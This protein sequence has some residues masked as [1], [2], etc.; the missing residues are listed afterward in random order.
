MPNLC[1]CL[2]PT[3]LEQFLLGCTNEDRS[4]EIEVH[5]QSCLECQQKLATL[6]GEDDLVRALRDRSHGSCAETP[7]TA[8]GDVPSELVDR[9]IPRFKRIA[10]AFEETI[11]APPQTAVAA[12][13]PGTPQG[14]DGRRQLGRYEIRG[15]LGRGG[16]GTVLH[17][18]DPLLNR[19]IAIKVLQTD[20]LAEEGATERLVREA[21]AAAAMEHDNIV[22]I[23]A[24][25]LLD[26]SPCIV[27]PLLKGESLQQRLERLQ[28]PI[29]VGEF[30][31]IAREAALGLAAAH[32]AGL[33]HCDIKP[34]NLWLESPQDRVIVLDFGLAIA[35]GD[36]D[37]H[38]GR[39]SG[40]PG[41]LAPEQA[42]GKPLDQRTDIFSLG[43][44]LYRMATGLA[45]FTGERRLR[46]LWTVLS[47]PPVA[48]CQ[49]NSDLPEELSDLIAGM[50][51]SEPADRPTT[52]N[53]VV[54]VLD[55]FLLR[56]AEQQRRTVRRRWML[57]M[58]GAALLSGVGVGTWA[59][60]N[61]PRSAPPVPVTI[62]GDAPSLDVII[63]RD[64]RD[65]PLTLGP[66]TTL[67]LPPGDYQV[68]PVIVADQRRL[69]PDHFVVIAAQPTQAVRIALVGEIA[70]QSQ[71][72]QM[73]T[74]V[75]QVPGSRPPVIF[76]VGQDRALVRWE[77]ATAAPASFTN[78]DYMARCIAVSPDGNEVAT[79]GGNKTLPQETIVELRQTT[80]IEGPV[81][82]LEGHTRLISALAYSPDGK[83][84]ASGDAE[85][86]LLWNRATGESQRLQDESLPREL[87]A[88]LSLKFSADGRHLLTGGDRLTQ[89]DLTAVRPHEIPVPGTSSIRAVDFLKNG[90]VIAG[91]E[92]VVWIWTEGHMVLRKLASIGRPI[93]ALV[94]SSDGTRLLTGDAE[95][96]VRIWS[97]STGEMLEILRGHTRAVHAVAFVEPGRQAVS[98]S[99]DGTVRLWQL[100]FAR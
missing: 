23:Y 95:G 31:R 26:D 9:L 7:A 51:S 34:S 62:S 66:E 92:G 61:A 2:S 59:M 80:Q 1:A 37:R 78:L 79:A 96:S 43:C 81:R 97:V 91:D 12:K 77:P 98:A 10:N 57:G 90:L 17:G 74:G 65:W 40:T 100:P 70:R 58:F 20:W 30:V 89:W 8:L 25:E 82:R 24:V 33:I 3:E 71:H 13:I 76:S 56:S 54:E 94:A 14:G 84:L 85:G 35:L 46:A 52:L 5:L 39:I 21:Q 88:V 4:Q 6:Q 86:T 60:F 32:S 63:H 55:A 18:F 22:P 99:A 64:G 27:M 41:Y 93:L 36:A 38:S 87:R 83:W 72:T 47:D 68:R 75:V 16:M 50:M 28:G 29:P 11:L 15:L 49:V 19:S 45:P 48:A 44:V 73:V 42:R 67:S 69:V 53:Q